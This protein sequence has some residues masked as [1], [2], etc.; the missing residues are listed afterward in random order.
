MRRR[1]CAERCGSILCAMLLA[2]SLL[3]GCGAPA[4]SAG[5]GAG[6]A[7]PP[8]GSMEDGTL[9]YTNLVGGGVQDTVRRA[10]TDAGV[11]PERLD[12]FFVW[13]DDFNACMKD[14]PSYTLQDAFVTIDAPVVDYGDYGPMSRL[15]YKT[16]GR[17]YSDVLCRIAAFQLMRDHITVSTPLA[18]A[19]WDTGEDQWLCSD[20]D[21]IENFP[22][23]A[24]SG[25]EK[26]MYFTLF[27]PISVPDD[28]APEEMY[29]AIAGAW[30]DRGVSFADGAVSLATIWLL[31]DGQTAAGHAAVLAET[32]QGLL[33]VE[34]TNPQAPYQ[35]AWFADEDQ[36]RQYMYE[37][38]HIEDVRYGGETGTY[39]VLRNDQMM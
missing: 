5:D 22:L 13:V 35:A 29:G 18:P 23:V 28:A 21:A 15:W 1:G 17:K 31:S 20:G 11:A 6:D 24:F 26:E 3:T 9:T 33:L 36:V 25:A 8:D 7:A 30:A 39:L 37:S 34:K 10:C 12:K 38:I 16:N 32:E 4:P 19:D 14:C 27:D 2:A